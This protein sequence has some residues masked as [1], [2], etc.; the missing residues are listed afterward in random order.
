MEPPKAVTPAVT[1]AGG[2]TRSKPVIKKREFN[3]VSNKYFENEDEKL[4]KEYEKLKNRV[5]SKYWEHHDYD[6]IKGKYF[7]VN[8]EKKFQDQKELLKTVQGKSQELNYPPSIQYSEGHSY[9]IVNNELYDDMKLQVTMTMQNRTL[10]RM[11]R[12]LTEA[13]I[14]EEE[15]KKAQLDEQKRMSRIKFRRWET[16]LDRGYHTIKNEVLSNPP[17]PLPSRPATMWARLNTNTAENRFN[18]NNEPNHGIASAPGGLEANNPSRFPQKGTIFTASAIDL[19]PPS[20]GARNL[21]GGT[22]GLQ[23]VS[24]IKPFASNNQQQQSGNYTGRGAETDRSDISNL[25]SVSSR[26][27]G[28]YS[29]RDY[30]GGGGGYAGMTKSGR[31]IPSLD[32]TRAEAGEPVKY[33]IPD[34]A[35]PG[36]AIPMVRT[37]GLSGYRS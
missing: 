16:E 1:S 29:G 4:E 8:K 21:S 6:I 36:L 30:G 3:I 26:M 7:D 17:M 18:N 37:G 2:H 31:P 22:N 27:H 15:E 34:N 35:P 20:G 10:N 9:N 32:L 11:T 12:D 24:N 25:S 14:K 13:R 19:P 33:K 5:V 23:N 28:S